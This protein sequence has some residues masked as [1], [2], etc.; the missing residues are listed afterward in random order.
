MTGGI[1]QDISQLELKG[2][3]LL[4]G[5]NY[6]EID[7]A[8][9]GYA[10]L[11]GYERFDGQALASTVAVVQLN[12]YGDD[13]NTSLLLESD[14][15]ETIEDISVYGHTVVNNGVLDDPNVFKFLQSSYY[16]NGSS[17]L[18]ITPVDTT[19]DM[20]DSD[21][22]IDFLLDP[23]D[24]VSTQ[25]LMSKGISYQIQVDNHRVVFKYSTDG[26]SWDG[27][28][29]SD[30]YLS[31]STRLHF[32]LSRKDGTVY[33]FFDGRRDDNTL[34]IGTDVIFTN[35]S[36]LTIGTNFLGRLDEI[37]VSNDLRW[38]I[39]FGIPTIP[40]SSTGYYTY[41]ID[42]EAREAQ[43]A[44]IG[45]VPGEGPILGIAMNASGE[46]GAV[47]NNVGSTNSYIYRA[48]PTGWSAPIPGA[49]YL[50]FE[51]GIDTHVDYPGLQAGETVTG[52][53]SGATATIADIATESGSWRDD[54][55]ARDAAGTIVLKDVV[56]DFVD[57]DVLDN[58]GT[59]TADVV[60]G[61]YGEYA[62]KPDGDY[63]FI[64]ARFDLLIDLQRKS[65]PFF[66]NG[67]N[68]P[69]YFD[70]TQLIPIFDSGLPDA[71]GVFANHVVEFKNRLW[72]AYPDGRLWYSAV[73]DPLNWDVATGGAGEIYMEDE[74]TALQVGQGDVLVVFCRNSIQIIKSIVDTNVSA[75]TQ[76]DYAFFNETFSNVSGAITNTVD[77]IL[78]EIMYLDDRGITKLSAS[79]TYGDFSAASLSKSVQRTILEKKDLVVTSAVH[80]E[81]NQYRLFFNDMT[82]LIFTFDVEKKVKGITSVKYNHDMTCFI[83]GESATG[84]FKFLF[85]SSDGYVYR[86]DSG[87]SFDGEAIETKLATSFYSYKSPTNWKR[88][89]KITLEAQADKD[90]TFYGTPEY[91]YRNPSVPR[92]SASSYNST[93]YGGVWGT[94]AWGMFTYGS[95]EVQSPALYL[96]GYGNN[97]SMVITTS[98]K[99]AEP[100]VIN[101]IITEFSLNGRKM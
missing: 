5:V 80:R 78:G 65:V 1:K 97:M 76:A 27:T 45:E 55:T 41:Q 4:Q 57:T 14:L 34:V 74:I 59:V 98:D 24:Q 2:G 61:S 26:I 87:T 7:G 84:E 20:E 85:G 21:F 83:E 88:F 12:D 39:D 70:G 8:Y 48:D 53:I 82:G 66:T 32:A 29:I 43:R 52:S 47:R 69:L 81:N 30:E 64:Q 18:D 3:E 50:E 40:Y 16:F 96:S 28:L 23:L 100:H 71:S 6:Q 33:M 22:T 44:L 54:A 35:A 91:N 17:T 60:D 56:G 101:S 67:V 51:N 99:Y 90:F 86:M 63:C 10:S 11:P 95:E 92:S 79:D 31:T 89:R 36:D 77:R 25:T 73:G 94:D 19:L 75:K 68:Y 38:L 58:G 9:H 62:M 42:D 46:V 13:S 49:F 93:G 15:Q 72:L 37:R